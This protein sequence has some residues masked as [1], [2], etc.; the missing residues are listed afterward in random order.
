VNAPEVAVPLVNVTAPPTWVPPLA[1]PLALVKG[2]QMKKLTVPVGVTP[3]V[4]VTVALSVFEP[5]RVIVGE[6]GALAVTDDAFPTVKH[7]VVLPSED[8][9]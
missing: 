3:L 9:V 7:S 2:P 6:L 5:P 8:G 4:P 1:Q